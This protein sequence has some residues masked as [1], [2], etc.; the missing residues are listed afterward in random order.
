MKTIK[1]LVINEKEKTTILVVENDAP[2][3]ESILA[4]CA[5]VVSKPK[6]ETFSVKCSSEDAYD[7]Y[8]GAALAYVEASFG[9]KNQFRKWVDSKAVNATTKE[10][11]KKAKADRVAKAKSKNTTAKKTSKKSSKKVEVK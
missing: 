3:L 10:D 6:T 2:T 9:S 5:G 8:V 11:K 1:H 4:K 7:R